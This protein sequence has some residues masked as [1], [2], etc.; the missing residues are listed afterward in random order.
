MNN[1]ENSQKRVTSVFTQLEFQE[2]QLYF[3]RKERS[4]SSLKLDLR[5]TENTKLYVI[6]IKDL[7]DSEEKQ[8][9]FI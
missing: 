2:E 8:K 4:L 7:A 9:F 3:E 6:C 5:N 1:A